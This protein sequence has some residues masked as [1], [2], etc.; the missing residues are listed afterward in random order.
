MLTNMIRL[1]RSRRIA[2]NGMAW[3]HIGIA[4]LVVFAPVA[5]EGS[6]YV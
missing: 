2:L 1:L 3:H 4:A 5:S 6:R